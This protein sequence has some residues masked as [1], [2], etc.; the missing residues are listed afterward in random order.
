MYHPYIK[1]IL[2]IFCFHDH[3]LECMWKK[4]IIIEEK[5][6]EKTKSQ[7]QNEFN[8]LKKCIRSPKDFWF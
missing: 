3:E 5:L 2:L 1:I 8:F 6:K 4:S 7:A